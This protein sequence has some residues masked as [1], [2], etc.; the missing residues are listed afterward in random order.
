VEG[1]RM[2]SQLEHRDEETEQVEER[3]RKN[4]EKAAKLIQ[5]NE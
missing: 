5:V 1:V 3:R 4:A 2:A